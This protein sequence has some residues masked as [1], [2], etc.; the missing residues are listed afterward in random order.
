GR[1]GLWLGETLLIPRHGQSNAQMNPNLPHD[2][3]DFAKDLEFGMLI[4]PEQVAFDY[5]SQ[6]GSTDGIGFVDIE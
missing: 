5:E 4:D 6:T 3:T 2:T 1:E